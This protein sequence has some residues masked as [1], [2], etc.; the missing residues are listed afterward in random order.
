MTNRFPLDSCPPAWTAFIMLL[1]AFAVTALGQLVRTP[2]AQAQPPRW[3][4]R[5]S[6]GVHE[7]EL[8]GTLHLHLFLELSSVNLYMGIAEGVEEHKELADSCTN[9][10]IEDIVII[11]GEPG[12]VEF[13]KM[14]ISGC[15]ESLVT[16]C[17]IASTSEAI[18]LHDVRGKLVYD[19]MGGGVGIAFDPVEYSVMV[20]C[21]N[22]KCNVLGTENVRSELLPHLDSFAYAPLLEDGFSQLYL[23]Y[24]ADY[25]GTSST[26]H[27]TGEGPI[28]ANRIG[29]EF[30]IL[31]QLEEAPTE[32]KEIKAA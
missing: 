24:E 32:D 27:N 6:A 7:K 9:S 14:T 1:V 2:T 16:R 29:Y 17:H 25:G 22:G 4:V 13:G 19:E 23:E 21:K 18:D 8:T 11:G 28:E 20:R 31:Q 15:S 12:E 26:I 3:Y 10:T 30:T 5:E